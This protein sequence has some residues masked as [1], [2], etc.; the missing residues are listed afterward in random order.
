MPNRYVEM[1]AGKVVLW[2]G[3][4]Y[5]KAVSIRANNCWRY[6][7]GSKVQIADVVCTTTRPM[8]L[9]INAGR[10]L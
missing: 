7:Q 8:G 2:R 1:K 6:Y 5:K 9:L 3:T 10:S 4:S